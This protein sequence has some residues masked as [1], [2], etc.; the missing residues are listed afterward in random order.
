MSLFQNNID[1]RKFNT[2]C[3][4]TYRLDT[5][6]CGCQHDCSYCY[7]KSLLNFRGLWNSKE[8]KESELWEIK[9]YISQLKKDTV[10]KL[11]GMTDCFMPLELNKRVTYNTIKLLNHYQINYLIV[12]K[13]DLVI[14]PEYLEIYNPDLAH[15]QITITSTKND[16]LLIEK[17]PSY[18]KRIK[19]VETLYKLGFDVSVRLSPFIEEFT[20]IDIIN[21]IKCNKILIEFLKVNH[22]I[23]KT[24]K[25]DYIKYSLKHGGYEHLQ[26][27]EKIKQAKKITEF[28]QKSVGEYVNEH[29]EYFKNNVNF[30]INDCCNLTLNLPV[31]NNPVQQTL[32]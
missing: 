28:E 30:N 14:N 24:M 25:I 18:N 29:H 10:V 32:F 5:Y 17:A 22:W 7:S 4:Y 6:G 12:T 9:K 15:F 13:S 19:A 1:S 20:N 23:K 16:N 31:V 8:P 3:N 2:W 21:N 26:L 27:Y 11:G